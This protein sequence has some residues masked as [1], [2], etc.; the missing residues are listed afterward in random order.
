MGILIL[1][2]SIVAVLVIM[3]PFFVFWVDCKYP[4]K[5]NKFEY[6]NWR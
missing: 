4:S 2:L 5:Q 3:Y 6:T 1:L